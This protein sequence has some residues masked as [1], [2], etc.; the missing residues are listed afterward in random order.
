[1][2]AIFADRRSKLHPLFSVGFAGVILTLGLVMGNVVQLAVFLIG[3]I[4]LYA[5]F[6]LSRALWKVA[7]LVLP[8]AVMIALLSVVI[9]ENWIS[10][11]MTAGRI[12]LLGMSSVPTLVIQPADLSRSLNQAGVPRK[13]AL[14]L[15]VT[16]RFIPVIT[17]EVWRI[18]EAMKVRGVRFRWTNLKHAYRALVMPLLVRLINISDTLALSIET[19]GFS[20]KG[21]PSVY[22][23]VRV[24]WRDYLFSLLLIMTAAGIFLGVQL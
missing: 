18:Q 19:R 15:L 3:V 20:E 24:S 14:A 23:M 13:L 7:V 4:V 9:G 12:T 11:L 22:R 6:G 21:T 16:V 17:A 8:I 2:L 10:A 1:M 5:A